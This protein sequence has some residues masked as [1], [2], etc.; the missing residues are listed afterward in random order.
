[1]ASNKKFGSPRAAETTRITASIAL[2]YRA[3]DAVSIS[4]T[5]GFYVNEHNEMPEHCRIACCEAAGKHRVLQHFVA[6]YG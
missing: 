4:F 2:K 3:K 6:A 5:R 1:V